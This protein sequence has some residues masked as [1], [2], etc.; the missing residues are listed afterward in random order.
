MGV[1]LMAIVA[2]GDRRRIYLAPTPEHEA[3]AIVPDLPDKPDLP[4]S[5][6]PQYM[7]T[8]RYGL[9]KFS[10]LFTP[11]QLYALSTFAQLVAEARD[12]ALVWARESLPDDNVSLASGGRGAT[13]YADSVALYLA[14]GVSKLVDRASTLCGWDSTAA[15]EKIRNV[16]GRQAMSMTW[17]FAE[18]NVLNRASGGFSKVF[19][20]VPEALGRLKG[21]P[22]GQAFQADAM[23]RDFRGFVVSTDPPY[24]DNVPYADLSD[25]FYVWLRRSLGDVFPSLLA[26]LQTPK[27]DELV[28]DVQRKGGRAEAQTFFE[29]GFES[30]FRNMRLGA[31]TRYPMTVFYA[32]RQTDGDVQG[33]ASTGWQT[34]LEGMLRAGWEV[35]ATW[36]MRTE[37]ANRMRNFESNALASSIVLALRPREQEAEAVNRRGFLGVLK[38][39]LPGALRKLQEGSV[40]PVD[41]AQ[42]AI[43]PGMSVFSRFSMVIEADG[44][45]MSVRTALALINQ[46]LDETLTEQEGDFDAV[47]RFCVRWF[48]EFGWNEAPFGRADD[49]AKATNASLGLL[50]RSGVFRASAGRARLLEPIHM[51]PEWD[52]ALDKEISV[53]EVAVRVA[54]ALQTVGVE[55]AAEWMGAAASRV[56]MDAV[57]ELSYLMYSICER[58]GWADSALLFNGL[59]TSWGDLTQVARQ[60]PVRAQQDQLDL[61][62]L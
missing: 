61:E 14:F 21:T 12:M 18:G 41:L 42:A 8:P 46:V 49:L 36:P 25:Y 51:P 40:A 19:A 23:S 62:D 43:G 34:L 27:V 7:G 16:F 35:T 56:D 33:Q 58:K 48:S 53:W 6:H 26:T 20:P 17:D 44:A 13:A 29:E 4:L 47:T 31:D 38:S 28:A 24:Y 52:P 59:G 11:R 60:A 15:N 9:T 32:F 45:P 55:M 3:A 54:H 57:K 39:E 1:Q 22:Q 2:E 37:L 5:T 30:V 50:E 10:D